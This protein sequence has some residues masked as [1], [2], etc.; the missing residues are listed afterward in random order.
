MKGDRRRV[1]EVPLDVAA[2]SIA[3]ARPKS[4]TDEAALRP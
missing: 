1:I 4:S 2:G 3:L